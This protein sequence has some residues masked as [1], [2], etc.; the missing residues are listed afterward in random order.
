MGIQRSDRERLLVTFWHEPRMLYLTAYNA[1]FASLWASVFIRAVY[2]ARDGKITLFTATESQARW[3][4]TA[5]L[6]EVLH[7]AF[8]APISY[9]SY[10]APC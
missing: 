3:I 5:S 10:H 1:L 9:T 6:V 7:A 4:Q 2:H 8:G